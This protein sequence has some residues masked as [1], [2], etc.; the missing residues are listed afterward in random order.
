[1]SHMGVVGDEERRAENMKR[2]AS[3]PTLILCD[4]CGGTGNE[5]YAMYRACPTCGG[6]GVVEV[7]FGEGAT[8]AV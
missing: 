6:L 1:M 5:F 2:V 7:E 4:Y 3:D 8:D